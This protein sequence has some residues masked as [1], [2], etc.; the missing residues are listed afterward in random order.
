MEI[1]LVPVSFSS[2]STGSLD[3]LQWVV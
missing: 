2:K 1:E 3:L